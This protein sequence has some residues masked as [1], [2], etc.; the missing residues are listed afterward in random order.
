MIVLDDIFQQ[1]PQLRYH[2]DLAELYEVDGVT[3]TTISS[4]RFFYDHFE[5]RYGMAYFDR[6]SNKEILFKV[7]EQVERTLTVDND[8]S[9]VSSVNLMPSF[10]NELL[11]AWEYSKVKF[12]DAHLIK[13]GAVYYSIYLIYKKLNN[14]SRSTDTYLNLF[15]QFISANG[16]SEEIVAYDS[17]GR[18]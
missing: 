11:L 9:E 10:K 17:T 3:P 5:G 8:L 6:A 14:E 2:K 13:K 16:I 15:N 18:I 12:S 4:D 1:E 7:T